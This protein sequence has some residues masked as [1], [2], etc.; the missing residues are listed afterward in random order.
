MRRV[1]PGGDYHS[2]GSWMKILLRPSSIHSG[3][4][5][6]ARATAPGVDVVVA[7][8]ASAALDDERRHAHPLG[9]R[10]GRPRGRRA[11]PAP[12]LRRAAQA[13]R[14]EAG[15]G[16]ARPD[17]PGH[18][19]GPRG[20]PPARGRR[21]TPAGT[22]AAT[23]SPPPP[24][25]CAASSSTPPAARPAPSAAGGGSVARSTRPGSRPRRRPT[26]SWPSTTP[27]RRLAET[28]PVAARLVQ[29]RY[30]AGLTTEQAA[31]ALGMSVRSAYSTWSYARSWLRGAIR[32][33]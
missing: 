6:T 20:L 12:G 30:F 14:P 22:A 23:S 10:A 18:R 9:H 33:G 21:R 19:P 7:G 3:L 13:R 15:A 32:D 31:E 8:M 28:D 24:R 27:S 4:R 11:A 17:A 26:T 2:A 5:K 16:E 1:H 25:P 29:L